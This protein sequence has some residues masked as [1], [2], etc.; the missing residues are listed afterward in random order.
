[1]VPVACVPTG[2]KYL[3]H[4]ALKRDIGVYFEANGHGTVV[5]KNSALELIKKTKT[6]ES[7]STAERKAASKLDALLNVIN[8]SVGDALSD[9][10][11]VE[12]VLRSRGWN[13]IDWE[14][15]YA[16]LPNRQMKVK[17]QD[18]NVINTADAERKCTTP[19][20]LQEE[21]DKIVETYNSGRSFVRASGTEDVVRV[22]AEADSQEN[23]DELAAKVAVKVHMMAGGVGDAPSL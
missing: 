7:L 12:A 6:D 10:L 2:V 19:A 18:R 8:Q 3:H 21:I 5:V 20:G 13:V 11:L 4:E 17:V 16:D 14:K 9:I 15:T 23:A 22:Y 1:K